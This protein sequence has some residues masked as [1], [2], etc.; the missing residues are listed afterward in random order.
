MSGKSFAVIGLGQF[1]MTLAKELANADYDVL[2]IDDKDENIQEIAE[3][4]TTCKRN[5]SHKSLG[6]HLRNEGIIA[7]CKN[8]G[9][10]LFVVHV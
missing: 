1:G 7:V 8:N 3:S 5:G 9:Q 4:V 2:A 6:Y 10:S